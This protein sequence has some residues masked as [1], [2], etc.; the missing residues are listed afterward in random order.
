MSHY[1]NKSLETEI[2]ETLN[3]QRVEDNNSH[4]V[5]WCKFAFKGDRCTSG[6]KRGDYCESDSPSTCPYNK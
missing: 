5:D 6:I 1:N 2:R 3:Q 4:S